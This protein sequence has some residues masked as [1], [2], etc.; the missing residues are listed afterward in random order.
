MEPTEANAHTHT[1]TERETTKLWPCWQGS[2]GLPHLTN[3]A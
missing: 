1:H 2:V 3:G